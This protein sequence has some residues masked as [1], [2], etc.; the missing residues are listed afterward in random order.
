MITDVENPAV[1]AAQMIEFRASHS[2][3]VLS[4]RG[5]A[6]PWP[7]MVQKT[8]HRVALMMIG[9]SEG[10]SERNPLEGTAVAIR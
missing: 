2:R 9:P 10:P 3:E 7:L 6:H 8:D 4:Q 5:Y 1:T